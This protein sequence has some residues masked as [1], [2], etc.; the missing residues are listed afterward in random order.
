MEIRL[1]EIENEINVP[2]V[3]SLEVLGKTDDVVV[4]L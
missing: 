1:H 2:V 3:L 4:A